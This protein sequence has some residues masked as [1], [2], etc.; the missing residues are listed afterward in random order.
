MKGKDCLI[1]PIDDARELVRF[2]ENKLGKTVE[3]Y[4]EMRDAGCLG[5]FSKLQEDV[6]EEDDDRDPAD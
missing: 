1:I 3:T 4:T 5:I 2:I 6:K